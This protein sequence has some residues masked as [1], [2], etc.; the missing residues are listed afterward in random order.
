M[1][2][3]V[4]SLPQPDPD[5]RVFLAAVARNNNAGRVP[6]IELAVDPE[7]VAALLDTPR[8]GQANDADQRQVIAGDAVQLLHRLGYD[9]IKT[10]AVIPFDVSRLTA[11]D[12][13]GLGRGT[14]QW[15]NE[16]S[17]AIG[18]MDDLERYAWPEPAD[19]DYGPVEAALAA[20]PDGMAGIG[21]CG[22]VLEFGMDLIGMERFM[23]ATYDQPDLI[24][25]VLD[26]VGRT[27]EGVFENYCR[28]DRICALWLG[29]DLGSKNGLLVSPALLEAHVFPW[30]ARYAELAHRHGR[31]FLLHSCGKTGAVMPTLIEQAGIDAKHSFEDAIEPVER[32]VDAWGDRVAAL[33][34]VDVHLLADGDEDAVVSRTRQILEHAAPRGGYACGSGNSIANYVK[35]GN[36]LAMIETV[37]R[38]NA[39]RQ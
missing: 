1:H 12:T 17:G 2:P 36:Y 11:A 37:A 38:F 21:F 9:V 18:S 14:R 5:Y 25:A 28:M 3:R 19:V 26:R 7:M 6:L 31:P 24:A 22:G 13:A 27:V 23:Y 32:F 20:L 34:G 35:P 4:D 15:Q 10:S 8:P 30:Y 33:G 16:S 39:G 29:D